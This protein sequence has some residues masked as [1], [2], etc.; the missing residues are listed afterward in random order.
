MWIHQNP[1]PR[2]SHVG[3]CVVR[4]LSIILGYSWEK[5]YLELCIRGLMLADMPSSNQVW[6]SYLK[7]KGYHRESIASDCV[8][9]YTVRDFCREHPHGAYILGTGSHVIAIVD[10]HY[11]DDWDSGDENPIFYFVK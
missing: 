7:S 1:N 10:G 6:G 3:D 5:T 9:C 8:D 2:A 11:I 4:A